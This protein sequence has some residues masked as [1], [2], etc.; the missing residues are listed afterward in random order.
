MIDDG[1]IGDGDVKVI[2][3]PTC[4][5][6]HMARVPLKREYLCHLMSLPSKNRR[7]RWACACIHS[8]KI[9]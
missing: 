9:Y 3:Y 8:S 4:S 5:R 1:D 7:A 6:S 2:K